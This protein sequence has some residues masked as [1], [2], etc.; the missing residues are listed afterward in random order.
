MRRAPVILGLGLAL[1]AAPATGQTVVPVPAWLGVTFETPAAGLRAVLG[2]PVRVTRLPDE[3]PAGQSTASGKP[4]RKA[5]YVIS[6]QPL[7]YAIVT[8]RYG[9]VVGIEGYSPVAL[10]GEVPAVTDPSGVALGATEDAVLKAHPDAKHM[11]STL[12]PVIVAQISSRYLASYAFEGGRVNAIDWFARASTDPQRDGPPLAEPA[13]DS[14]A[15]AV[16][17]VAKNEDDG[18]RRETIW[19]AFHPCDK[20]SRWVKG[21]VATLHEGGRTYDAIRY[22]CPST[23][24]TRTVYFDIT[25]FYGK[26]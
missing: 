22:T 10:T 12:G 3:L 14:T 5:R 26:F 13:G 24:A 23:G 16:L 1:F 11:S 8:E 25:P 19:T 7:L 20:T 18:I 9:A 4:E 2:D 21:S 15:T 17:V 6:V